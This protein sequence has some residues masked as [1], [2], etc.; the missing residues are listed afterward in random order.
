MEAPPEESWQAFSLKNATSPPSR[1]LPKP[2]KSI[3][4]TTSF[5]SFML[6]SSSGA[7]SSSAGGSSDSRS[8]SDSKI[9][10]F[11]H[12]MSSPRLSHQATTALP[13]PFSLAP[14]S[15]A[16]STSNSSLKKLNPISYIRRRRAS[17]ESPPDFYIPSVEEYKEAG[18]IYGTRTHDWGSSPPV[19]SP[20]LP[21][22]SVFSPASC[23]H[24]PTINGSNTVTE[25]LTPTEN[26]EPLPPVNKIPE[27]P[28]VAEVEEDLVCADNGTSGSMTS[29]QLP[30][31]DEL[32]HELN[33]VSHK[34]SIETDL[35]SQQAELN[36]QNSLSFNEIQESA[37]VLTEEQL[38][39]DQHSEFSFEEDTRVGRNSSVNY[40]K[41]PR[42]F[43]ADLSESDDQEFDSYLDEY[44]RDY[45][46]DEDVEHL[47]GDS[48]YNSM[49]STPN[50]APGPSLPTNMVSPGLSKNVSMTQ[51]S[52]LRVTTHFSD[53]E[54]EVK[55]FHTTRQPY[56]H[57]YD[58]QGFMSQYETTF[59]GDNE[60]DADDDF[61]YDSLLDEVNAVPND[62]EDYDD[63]LLHRTG[64]RGYN[65]GL[66]KAKSYAFEG[67]NPRPRILKRQTSVIKVSEKT[68][69]TLFSPSPSL[70]V[71]S[72][73]SSSGSAYDMSSSI[74]TLSSENLTSLELQELKYGTF[75]K[76]PPKVSTVR[77]ASLT[78]ISERS[79]D[80]DY[81]V[82]N[83]DAYDLS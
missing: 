64:K 15:I 18:A 62:D 80:S 4:A 79:Y 56:M 35:N 28:F 63:L 50:L 81:S 6:N 38:S 17:T 31:L 29:E 68:T 60:G 65:V 11:R 51:V 75:L 32:K 14:A 61:N 7:G 43:D 26:N 1:A 9:S 27:L 47:F 2:G 46:D 55:S 72:S 37:P 12:S 49:P 42:A 54:D 66:R 22:S 52:P 67:R 10:P 19:T 16:S 57:D 40:H 78:P 24:S 30:M 20:I 41:I 33:S 25:G 44:N 70:S 59:D 76:D 3:R 53:D 83:N 36:Q 45:E 5:S 73:I 82:S 34:S 21:P 74:S 8:V 58:S 48:V 77:H 69:V 39:E 23:A 71:N 13:N